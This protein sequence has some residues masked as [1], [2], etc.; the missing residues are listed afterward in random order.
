MKSDMAANKEKLEQLLG[1]IKQLTS[2]TEEIFEREIYP[3][4]FFSQA[5][6]LTNTIQEE[7]RRIELRQIELFEKQMQAHQAQIQSIVR[8]PVSPEQPETTIQPT[9]AD[10]QSVQSN[11]QNIQLAAQPEIIK[12]PIPEPIDR[13]VECFVP[14]RTVGADLQSGPFRQQEPHGFQICES[15]DKISQQP[16]PPPLPKSESLTP[17]ASASQV[18]PNQEIKRVFTSNPDGV[19]SRID[20]KKVMTLNDRFLFCRELFANDENLMNRT[21]ADLNNEQSFESSMAYLRKKFD[22]DFENVHVDGFVAGLK[23]SFS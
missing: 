9:G 22:W 16:P 3:V 6:D 12:P 19:K 13:P 2:L 14:D 10:V 1:Y 15:Q 11:A 8:Q 18:M 17:G 21:I 5:Y 23:K 20:L 4:S 7:L